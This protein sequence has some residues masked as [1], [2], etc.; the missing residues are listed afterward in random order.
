MWDLIDTSAA[1]VRTLKRWLGTW[2]IVR[3]LRQCV[4]KIQSE[5]I[6]PVHQSEVRF[7]VRDEVSVN[8]S[9]GKKVYSA[10]CGVWDCLI[11]FTYA[12]WR[13]WFVGLTQF[14][15]CTALFLLSCT[16]IFDSF[17][18]Q[19]LATKSVLTYGVKTTEQLYGSRRELRHKQ[20]K[21]GMKHSSKIA[22]KKRCRRAWEN[23]I[24][25]EKWESWR[26]Y[27][28]KLS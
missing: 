11:D 15:H 22:W 19:S 25:V 21:S 23:N 7:N 3:M 8:E 1:Y 24:N 17:C 20:M 4:A 27:W 12:T 18:I 6:I 14:Q 9:T 28:I 10:F 5:E 2:N 16:G 13:V 26:V